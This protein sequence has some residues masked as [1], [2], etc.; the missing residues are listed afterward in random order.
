MRQ[1]GHIKMLLPLCLLAMLF[2][3]RAAIAE[4]ISL[5]VHQIAG[6]TV[7]LDWDAGTGT[8]DIYRRY[9]DESQLSLIGST[10]SNTWTDRHNRSVCN[11]TVYY[12]VRRGGDE[13]S[14]AINISDNE[15]TAPAQWGVVTVDQALQHIKLEWIASQDTDIMGYLVLEGT[16]S[17]VIDTV[18]GRTNTTYIYTQDSCTQVREFRINAFDSCRKAS[19]LTD[20]CNNMVL[21]IESEPRTWTLRVVGEPGRCSFCLGRT[22]KQYQRYKHRFHHY[23]GMPTSKSLRQG[24]LCRRHSRGFVEHKA[25]GSCN[26]PATVITISS[27]GLGV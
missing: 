21:H 9:P 12:V 1:S 8:T 24:R 20:Q 3:C 6:R 5:Q 14:A 19:A 7:Q 26:E 17:L 11:D 16:P 25:G 4:P 13:G 10:S 15:P 18:Y 27:Q 22:A 2:C 23:R